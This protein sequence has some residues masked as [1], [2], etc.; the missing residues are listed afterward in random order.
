MVSAGNSPG[1]DL[2]ATV[3]VGA[4]EVVDYVV[5]DLDPL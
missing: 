2:H 5:R 3:G 1:A 4:P